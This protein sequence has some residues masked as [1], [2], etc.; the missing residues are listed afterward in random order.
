MYVSISTA[1]QAIVLFATLTFAYPPTCSPI[2]CRPSSRDCAGLSDAISQGD[3]YIPSHSSRAPSRLFAI[4]GIE[5]PD[6][7]SSPQWENKVDIPKF[8]SFPGMAYS[9]ILL[10]FH[11]PLFS[12][13]SFAETSDVISLTSTPSSILPQ[14]S[15][16]LTP[17]HNLGRNLAMGYQPICPHQRDR[18]TDKP[19]LHP[20]NG[21]P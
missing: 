8:W 14:L 2:Y 16:G 11:S 9:P 21:S 1:V 3:F 17:S 4:P 10:L 18:H 19:L 12:G 5:R 13:V 6:G 20:G 15:G 7:I